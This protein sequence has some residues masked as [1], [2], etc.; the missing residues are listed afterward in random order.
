MLFYGKY[1]K[2]MLFH[3]NVSLWYTC[4]RYASSLVTLACV[5]FDDQDRQ[6]GHSSGAST[7]RQVSFKAGSLAFNLF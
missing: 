3:G 1:K 6:D 5:I 2:S 7:S 4:S